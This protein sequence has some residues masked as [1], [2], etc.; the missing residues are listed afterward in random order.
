MTS[1]YNI[2]STCCALFLPFCYHT[3]HQPISTAA[4]LNWNWISIWKC[5]LSHRCWVLFFHFVV[6]QQYVHAELSE[7]IW[8]WS[9]EEATLLYFNTMYMQNYST[10]IWLWSKDEAARDFKTLK[11]YDG[12]YSSAI[13]KREYANYIIRWS[14]DAH[15]GGVWQ[16]WARWMQCS[17][18]VSLGCFGI[19]QGNIFGDECLSQSGGEEDKEAVGGLLDAVFE[20]EKEIVGR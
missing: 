4:S 19:W 5:A 8:L 18:W 20:E 6:S 2:A 16:V 3:L 12:N 1:D 9:K 7:L 15:F 10:L 11:Q 14:G 13:Q 17:W